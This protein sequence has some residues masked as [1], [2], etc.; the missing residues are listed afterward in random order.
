MV[1]SR[2][3][4]LLARWQLRGAWR[5]MLAARGPLMKRATW[6][7]TRPRKRTRWKKGPKRRDTTQQAGSAE[8]REDGEWIEKE[9]RRMNGVGE[10]RAT[11]TH[12]K[13]VV[14]RSRMTTAGQA[15]HCT[16]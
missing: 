12:A 4:L 1:W 8:S 3:F 7:W 14:V 9:K 5:W 16:V 13:Q 15:R 10:E 6:G 11:G 2:G